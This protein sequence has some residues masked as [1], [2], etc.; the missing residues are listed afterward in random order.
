[1]KFITKWG[2]K[3]NR[4]NLHI[5]ISGFGLNYFT[6]PRHVDEYKVKGHFFQFFFIAIV[7]MKETK[8]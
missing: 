7:Y 2:K 8:S 5:E 4:K 6:K 3:G 1:M